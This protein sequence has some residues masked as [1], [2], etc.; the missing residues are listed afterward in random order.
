MDGIPIS[1]I[2]ATDFSDI[3]SFVDQKII[4]FNATISE[5]LSMWNSSIK[6]EQLTKAAKIACIHE[7]I[8]NRPDGYEHKLSEN[9]SNVSGGEKARLEIARAL[10]KD[11]ALLVLDEA[12]AALD[13]E[14]ENLVL[15]QI[16]Q[17]CTGGIIISHR[18]EP[19]QVCDEIIVFNKG[20]LHKEVLMLN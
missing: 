15:Q 11:P 2:K 5:N 17:H 20:R 18:I 7:W 10:A 9:G 3:I 4:L 1:Q 8:I 13:P 19:I 6:F 16:R 12:T 14:T